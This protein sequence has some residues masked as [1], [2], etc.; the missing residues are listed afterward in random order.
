MIRNM[1]ILCGIMMMVLSCTCT[2]KLISDTSKER[3][4]FGKTGGFTNI[5]MEYVLIDKDHLFKVESDQLVKVR[6]INGDQVKTLETL[7]KDIDLE[8]MTLNETGNITYHI[9]LVKQG[10]EKI[11][12]WSDTTTNEKIKELYKTLF[13][14]VKN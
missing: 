6:K 14:I 13:A 3:I 9:K 2:E 4:Y 1:F 8:Q 11:I 10:T 12:T 5:P 7:M